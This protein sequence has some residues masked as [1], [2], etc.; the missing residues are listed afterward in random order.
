MQL[1]VLSF[2]TWG[3]PLISRDRAARM[4]AIGRALMEINADVI[5][6]Q[7]VFYAKDR[8]LLVEAAQ[9]AG[10]THSHYFHSGVMGSGLLT[11][12]R[13]PIVETSFLRFR[14]NGRPQD[15]VRV[16]Y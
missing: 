4:R 11:L 8:R 10:F 9:R 13:F 6:L 15:F 14:L 3:V 7:E 5:G 12:S 16:D 1:R 2:N